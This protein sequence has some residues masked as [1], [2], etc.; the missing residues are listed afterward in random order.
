MQNPWSGTY[1]TERNLR[2]ASVLSLL[3]SITNGLEEYLTQSGSVSAVELLA[4]SGLT[5]TLTLPTQP[6]TCSMTSIT[7]NLL[8]T[9]KGK[10]VQMMMCSKDLHISTPSS[11]Q[12]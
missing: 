4:L 5:L 10:K 11:S 8:P 6:A 12:S 1:G 7:W 3:E 9:S 2:Q